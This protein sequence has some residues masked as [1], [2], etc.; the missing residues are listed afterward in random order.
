MTR[1]GI[2]EQRTAEALAASAEAEERAQRE[3]ETAA[4]ELARLDEPSWLHV[5]AHAL[6]VISEK[7]TTGLV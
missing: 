4:A 1:V 2:V 6:Q 5:P 7:S 3:A